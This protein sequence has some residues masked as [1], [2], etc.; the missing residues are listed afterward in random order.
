MKIAKP[1]TPHD[2][3][4]WSWG[5]AESN[6]ADDGELASVSCLTGTPVRVFRKKYT[7]RPLLTLWRVFTVALD[8]S[9]PV[10]TARGTA[11]DGGLIAGTEK[12]RALVDSSAVSTAVDR[13]TEPVP[14]RNYGEGVPG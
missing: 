8:E 4:D 10:T 14:P 13:I 6:S 9:A 12:E 11:G 3:C 1:T 5:V 2:R 7:L